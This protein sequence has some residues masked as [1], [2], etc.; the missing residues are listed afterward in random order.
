[1]AEGRAAA[2]NLERML[3]L[4]RPRVVVL[5]VPGRHG[6]DEIE[7]R[8]DTNVLATASGISVAPS[9]PLFE[10]VLDKGCVL[11][12]DTPSLCF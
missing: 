9:A 3:D 1:M 8:D 7:V 2:L 11:Q 4:T 5:V 12:S 10:G 6:D